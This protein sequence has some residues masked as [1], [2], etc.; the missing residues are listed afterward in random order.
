MASFNI[1]TSLLPSNL[2]VSTNLNDGLFVNGK[3]FDIEKK[4]R[5][6]TIYEKHRFAAEEKGHDRPK[7]A[8]IAREA[9]VSRGTVLKIEAELRKND[10]RV[11]EPKKAIQKKGVGVRSLTEEDQRILLELLDEDPF[12]TRRSY[13]VELQA[14]TGTV[15]SF[16]TITNFFLRGFP[17]KGSLRQP[18]LIPRDKF[19]QQNIEYYFEFVENIQK[20]DPRRLKFGDEKLLKG[21]EVYCKKGRRNVITGEVPKHIV[22]GDFRN[23]YAIIGFCG[24]D[25]DAPCMS[26]EIH[27]EKNDALSFSDAFIQAIVEGFL[28][29]GDV[30]VLDNAAIH[31][32]G[33][34]RGL[35][36]WLWTRVGVVVIPLP[37][38]SPELNPQELVWRSLTMKLRSIRVS[39]ETHAAAKEAHQIL[40][41]MLTLVLKKI[42][43]SAIT[44]LKRLLEPVHNPHGRLF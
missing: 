7:I 12:R 6:A 36:D 42:T 43:A 34:N 29:P 41:K 37:T 20:I 14:R 5:I 44:L 35:E 27:D 32:K 9:G 3:A 2:K 19:K 22:N 8:P 28:R 30:L 4:A 39:S 13:C 17:I 18:D 26:F 11:E 1:D 40:E 25:P 21:R 15:I 33:E 10:G 38:R 16:S 31:M 24:I 23:T